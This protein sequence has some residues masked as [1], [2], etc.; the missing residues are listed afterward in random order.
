LR[1]RALGNDAGDATGQ[2][3]EELIEQRLQSAFPCAQQKGDE[4]GKR[5]DALAGEVFGAAAMLGDEGRIAEGLRQFGED[6]GM[7]SAKPGS[8][9][10]L[11]KS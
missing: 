9:I 10:F 6:F 3:F 1:E 11:S 8:Y 7:D 2:R 5:E 4:D